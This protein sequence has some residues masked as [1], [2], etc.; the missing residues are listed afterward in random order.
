MHIHAEGDATI[1][2]VLDAIEDVQTRLGSQGRRHTMCHIAL[3]HPDDVKRFK[4]L[5]VIANGTP[6]WATNYNGVEVERFNRLYGAKRVEERVL[7]YGDLIRSGATVTFG[8]DIPGVDIDEIP[9]LLQ[10]EAAVTRKRPGFPD[11]P[12]MVVRQRMSVEEAICAYTINGDYQLRLEDQ[13]GSIEVGK[14]ADLIVLGA[15]LF[16]VDS[17]DIHNVPV[18]L[19]LMDGKARHDRLQT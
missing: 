19:T 1:R 6:L 10:L 18:L 7:P 4:S 15:N 11:D 5:G 14:K 2:I 8:A 16:G 17:E 13:I 12:A 3:A 9:P